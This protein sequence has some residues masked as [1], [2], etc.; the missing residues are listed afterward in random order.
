[1]DGEASKKP[2][3]L[4]AIVGFS[5][6]AK[7]SGAVP[8]NATMQSTARAR[9][10]RVGVTA[11]FS[12]AAVLLAE[13]RMAKLSAHGSATTDIEAGAVLSLWQPRRC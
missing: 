13:R 12:G 11:R 2:T 3:A 9:W 8:E 7:G 10:K 4:G 5:G 6:V 1:M